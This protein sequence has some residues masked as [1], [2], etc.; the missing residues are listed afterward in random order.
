MQPSPEY[1]STCD[2]R[3]RGVQEEISLMT[4][5]K[6]RWED[7]NHELFPEVLRWDGLGRICVAQG[8]DQ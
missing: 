4:M 1:E 8:R 5:A 6:R 2:V 7:K 3:R